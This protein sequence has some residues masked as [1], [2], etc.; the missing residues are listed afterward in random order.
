MCVCV[1]FLSWLQPKPF[2]CSAKWQ[3][4][5]STASTLT[6]I[7]DHSPFDQH[8]R[9]RER[10]GEKEGGIER[11]RGRDRGTEREGGIERERERGRDRGTGQTEREREGE[12]ETWTNEQIE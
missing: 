8:T 10:E 5:H 3:Q 7:N 12:K 2:S 9:E 6:D 1:C 4:W 11:E